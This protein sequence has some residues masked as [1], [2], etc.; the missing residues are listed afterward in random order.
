[1]PVGSSGQ[2]N[3][4]EVREEAGADGMPM[5]APREEPVSDLNRLQGDWRAVAGERVGKAVPLAD[6]RV[7]RMKFAGNQV[8]ATFPQ[9]VARGTL[10]L[11][12]TAAPKQITIRSRTDNNMA[13]EGIYRFDG[14]KLV[15]CIG[16]FNQE[17]PKRF[18][19]DAAIPSLVVVTFEREPAK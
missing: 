14:D 17:R 11:N 9:G 12:P 1:M 2:P 6:I 10:T 8:E 7:V 13:M 3:V 15:L 19:S 18:A 5:V 16:D 4:V